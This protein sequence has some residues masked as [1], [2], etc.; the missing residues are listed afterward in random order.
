MLRNAL[1]RSA[2]WILAYVVD[3]AWFSTLQKV[4]GSDIFARLPLGTRKGGVLSAH[5]HKRRLSILPRVLHMKGN[6]KIYQVRWVFGIQHS[7]L[8]EYEVGKLTYEVPVYDTN[9]GWNDG[10]GNTGSVA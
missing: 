10:A 1:R 9:V 3:F 6:K 8:L 7:Q 5:T 2:V 4:R